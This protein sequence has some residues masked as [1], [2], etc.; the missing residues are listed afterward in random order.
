MVDCF[1][2]PLLHE[3]L[4]KLILSEQLIENR[5]LIIV[6]VSGG[7]DSLS[8]LH[9]LNA[10][11]EE[12][13]LSYSLHVAHLNHGLRGK[14]AREDAEFVRCEAQKIGLPCTVARVD[15]SAY[16][17]HRGLSLEDAA[18]R[19]R[20]RFLLQL[21]KKTGASRIAVGHNRDDQVE[22][23]LLNFLRGTG[24]AGL[25]GM[26]IK[27]KV[28]TEGH[29]LIRPLLE[30][31]REELE[32]Y[33]RGR[34]LS[35]RWDETNAETH[36][37]RNKIR[38]ELLPFLEKEYNPNLRQNMQRLSRLTTWDH[39]LLE[40]TAERHLKSITL[41][42]GKRRL[43]LDSRKLLAKHQALQGRI[44]RR[45]VYR[46][47]GTIP[48]EVG[49]NQ[50]R[51]VLNLARQGPPHGR[52][53][54]PFNLE[55]SRSYDCLQ[56]SFREE[57]RPFV[58]APFYLTVP[59]KKDVPEKGIFLQA[60]RLPLNKVAWP[61]AS[62]KAAYFDYHAVWELLRGKGKKK[63]SGAP[64]ELLVRSRQAGD[65]FHPLGAPGQRKLKKYFIDQKIP[66]QERDQI[67]LVLAG[68]EIIWIAGRQQ[69]HV[70]RITEKT[71]SVLVLKL[72]SYQPGVLTKE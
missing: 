16:A 50:I 15:S 5:D 58:A 33:C 63:K 13:D 55:A 6:A 36:F 1:A 37:L 38:L 39:D 40:K 44:L 32:R 17:R 65:R 31:S 51:S 29:Y 53:H 9:I 62:R 42:V 46:L 27:R 59:G 41:A 11:Q 26:K 47:L 64:M 49:Y 61:P 72:G 35:P 20:Y 4:K 54:L 21:A 30:T 56:I 71:E 67:P 52:L 12:V 43:V 68:E 48:R 14:A 2:G 25:A 45:A 3:N 19:L 23:L 60:E 10:L 57:Q 22:T 66:L 28:G 7:A 34:G 70:C 8:L 18:R 24:P 69:A